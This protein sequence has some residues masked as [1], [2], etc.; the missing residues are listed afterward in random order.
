MTLYINNTNFFFNY[1]NDGKVSEM[2]AVANNCLILA[3][4]G[5][6]AALSGP[7][8]KVKIPRDTSF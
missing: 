7:V 5:G 1:H 4:N 2:V 6:I 8:L 3:I